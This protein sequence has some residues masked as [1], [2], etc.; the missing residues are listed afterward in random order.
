[1][2]ADVS[3][4]ELNV[5]FKCTINNSQHD[6]DVPIHNTN[7]MLMYENQLIIFYLYYYEYYRAVCT[8]GAHGKI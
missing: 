7:V 8:L 2:K 6:S 4:T 5:I 1:M 3:K